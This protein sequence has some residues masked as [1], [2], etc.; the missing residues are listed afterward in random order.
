MFYSL[1]FCF[2]QGIFLEYASGIRQY[3]YVFHDQTF[4][5]RLL[6]VA[7]KIHNIYVHFID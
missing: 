1:R 5:L 7:Y 2:G 6:E 3:M 4:F